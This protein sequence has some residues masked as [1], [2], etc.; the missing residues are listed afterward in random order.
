MKKYYQLILE[1]NIYRL[2]FICH[3]MNILLFETRV[4]NY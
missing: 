3:V 1:F 4:I 2:I